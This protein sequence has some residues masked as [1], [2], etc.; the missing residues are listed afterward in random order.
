M[1]ESVGNDIPLA[2]ALQPVVAN[3]RRRLNRCLHITRLHDAPLL[4]GAMSPDPSEAIGLQL[5][6][7][8]QVIGLDLIHA[9][10][11]LL[12]LRQDAEQ[13]LHVMAY[14][15]RD[16]IG[17]RKLAALAADIAAVETTLKV[18]KK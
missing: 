2:A 7:H 14:L 4:L 10:L 8:L 13:I 12:H 3:G 17:L 15:M 16:H 18:L 1:R 5:N 9:V 11:R 6:S